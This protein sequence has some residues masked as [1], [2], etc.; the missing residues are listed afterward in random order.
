MTPLRLPSHLRNG[1]YCQPTIIS[2]LEDG[3]R[4]MQ[5]EIFGPVVCVSPFST[6]QEAIERAND[7]QGGVKDRIELKDD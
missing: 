3:S 4:C 1:Y 5:D 7:V 2:G 6:E